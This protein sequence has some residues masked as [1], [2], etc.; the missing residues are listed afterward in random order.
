MAD[1]LDVLHETD[2]PA[3]P[4]PTFAA[5]LRRRLADLLAP[6]RPGGTMTLSDLTT[7]GAAARPGLL[8]RP[9]L[10]VDG[11]DA[12]IAFYASVFG[13]T[14]VG[15][16][17]R[18]DDGR[19]GHCELDIAGNGLYLADAYPEH[20]IAAPDPAVGVA[21]HLEVADADATVERAVAAGA[22]VLQAVD[23]RFYG[24]R[25]GTVLD[26][27]GHRWQIDAPGAAGT[28]P[29]EREA[30]MAGG[31]FAFETVD[32][33][34]RAAAPVASEPAPDAPGLG[35]FT[36]DAPDGDRAARFFGALLGWQTDRSG[37]GFHVAN[38]TPPGGIDTTKGAPGVTI[39]FRVADAAAAA[40]RVLELGGTVLSEA[41]SPSGATAACLDDQGVPFHLWQPA[42]GY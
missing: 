33:G 41:T 23:D 5:A 32:L 28:T 21:L 14:V 24:S 4:N 10:V 20:G 22:T 35:Y 3:S 27:F 6:Q 13:A 34:E 42:P 2:A 18:G 30:E 37:A 36:V 1:P 40:A 9:Y 12:A 38:I 15:E 29:A 7:A 11:A 17:I 31:G 25:S 39:Y 19:V 8:L 26:P 16:L